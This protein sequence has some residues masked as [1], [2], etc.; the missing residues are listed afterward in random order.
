MCA[1]RRMGYMS[2]WWH[3]RVVTCPCGH[4]V[5]QPGCVNL[6]CILGRVG[7]KAGLAPICRWDC[8]DGSDGAWGQLFPGGNSPDVLPEG[9]AA[10]KDWRIIRH[11]SDQ[12]LG[13]VG[14]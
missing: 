5:G 7:K 8:D 9:L 12:F 4:K 6:G 11:T 3:G 2:A 10:C 13:R 1:R 14:P